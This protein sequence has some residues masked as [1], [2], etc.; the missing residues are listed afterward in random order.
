MAA[1]A[2][3]HHHSDIL[4]GVNPEHAPRY[5]QASDT[6]PGLLSMA[7][8]CS[9]GGAWHLPLPSSINVSGGQHTPDMAASIKAST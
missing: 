1:K 5:W 6:S 4:P 7:V 9:S 2:R 3:A 8:R